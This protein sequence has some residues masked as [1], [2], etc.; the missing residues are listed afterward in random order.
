MVRHICLF[1]ILLSCVS[2]YAQKPLKHVSQ[3]KDGDLIFHI[4]SQP[5]AITDVTQSDNDYPIDHVAIYFHHEGK[6]AV[7]QS[8]HRGTVITP[9]D[10]VL[11]KEERFVVGR[12]K[13]HFHRQNS[14]NNALQYLGRA[15]DHLFLPDNDEIYCSELVQLSYV[16]RKGNLIFQT[17]PMSFH[18]ASGAVTPYW[19]QFY[20]QHDMEVPEGKPGTNP[21]E[22][23]RRKQI[24]LIYTIAHQQLK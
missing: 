12:I 6:P 2:G 14:I 4:A 15:Y 23:S 24:K 8:T 9:L 16:D 19:M 5:N 17:V 3:L 1:L 20:S 11:M 18:D 21:A 22:L 10:S 7:V 13:G